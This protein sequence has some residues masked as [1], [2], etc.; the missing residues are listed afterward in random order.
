[1]QAIRWWMSAQQLTDYLWAIVWVLPTLWLLWRLWSQPREITDASPQDTGE[2]AQR[3]AARKIA[4]DTSGIA[5]GGAEVSHFVD[6][7][8]KTIEL[9]GETAVS[10]NHSASSLSE[11]TVALSDH[12]QTVLQ[13][14]QQ[15]KQL[16]LEGRD[17]AV[18][19]FNAIH[20]LSQDVNAAAGHVTDLK[21]KADAI[22]KIT[23]VIDSLAAQTNLLAL[24]AAIEAA[25]A[26][27]AGR[28]FAV[29]AD[30]VRSL[31]A[32]T[33]ESTQHIAKMLTDIRQQTDSTS[34]LMNRVVERTA[35]TVQAMS[36]LEQRFDTITQ[37]VESSADA[38]AQIDSS[39]RDY[40]DTTADIADA[41]RQISQSLQDTGSRSEQISQQAFK[42]SQQT[43]GIFS[44]LTAW[45]TDTFE[46]QVLQE[47]Q[48]AAAACGKLLSQGLHT[49]TFTE[50]QLFSPEYQRVG[51]TEP[52]KYS[53]A[54]DRFTDQQFPAIQEP[55]LARLREVIYAGAVDRKG[56]FPTHNKRFSQPLTGNKQQ[57]IANN[58][59]KR[60]FNDPTGIRCGQHTDSMLLQTYKR[61][62]GEVM[63]DLSVPIYVNGKH[64]GG[65][66]IGFKA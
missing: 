49:G 61:D 28:G 32:K 52:A 17:F 57:D 4:Q 62:T 1:M 19:G 54:F 12:A 53:T 7:L 15:S 2:K 39:L 20:T 47:A 16:S 45:K 34:A 18:S 6:E 9:S 5:I 60:L 43:E 27:D 21:S 66:R 23:E 41:I 38:L 31:A 8:K 65:F 50:H 24:N 42:F 63:H 59:T 48:A 11:S 56:Y 37:G 22:E 58:R 46:Q 40:R 30:E 3:A 64:W 55:I 36:A 10:I 44:A 25:R 33:A 26:G 13:Q 35:D 14:A 51:T 29:V